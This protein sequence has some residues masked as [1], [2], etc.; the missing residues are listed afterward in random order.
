M[1]RNPLSK[2]A[3]I[4]GDEIILVTMRLIIEGGLDNVTIAN[5]ADEIRISRS[6][7]YQY[8]RDRNDI[9]KDVL[10]R[11]HSIYYKS[12]EKYISS[13]V[14]YEEKIIAY[15]EGSFCAEIFTRENVLIWLAFY[16]RVPFD[17]NLEKFAHNL[18]NEYFERL[19]CTL[20]N[21]GVE[22]RREARELCILIDG[23]WLRAAFE[24]GQLTRGEALDMTYRYCE[25]LVKRPLRPISPSNGNLPL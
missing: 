13:A 8:Y 5:I 12:I 14:S 25:M 23:L 1:P 6:A 19:K 4:R 16:G 2:K 17:N 21:L 9:L 20:S 10:A 22:G 11:V 3:E 7:I 18:D 24:K 15:I